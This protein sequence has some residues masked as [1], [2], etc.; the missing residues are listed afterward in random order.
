MGLNFL[1]EQGALP[2]KSITKDDWKNF[3]PST[4]DKKTEQ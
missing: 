2:F 4:K 3:P 1:L